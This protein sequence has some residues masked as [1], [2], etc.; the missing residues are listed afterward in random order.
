MQQQEAV[1]ARAWNSRRGATKTTTST[2]SVALMAALLASSIVPEASA[3][4]PLPSSTCLPFPSS[5]RSSVASPARTPARTPHSFGKRALVV[6]ATAASSSNKKKSTKKGLRGDVLRDSG[7][8]TG[9]QAND[10]TG[11]AGAG[12]A[13]DPNNPFFTSEFGEDEVQNTPEAAPETEAEKEKRLQEEDEWLLNLSRDDPDSYT[14]T[15]SKPEERKARAA[16]TKNRYDF[17]C[18]TVEEVA[19]S[20]QVPISW[21]GD[22]LCN[23]GVV[24]PIQWTARMG[25]LIDGEQA[26]ALLEAMHG[27]DHAIMYDMYTWDSL[28]ELA[29]SHDLPIA[30]VLQV[31]DEEGFALPFGLRS[32]LRLEQYARLMRRLGLARE[33]TDHIKENHPDPDY[34]ST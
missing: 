7:S 1:A 9:R 16:A 22:A 2:L 17:T 28:R 32:H 6:T 15:F 12:T 31:C 20:Y 13:F 3:F 34:P 27:W 25:D 10:T 8:S 14:E 19:R 30:K 18:L 4:L 21:V 11:S 23:F 26:Y 24:P 33:L 5:C 29:A